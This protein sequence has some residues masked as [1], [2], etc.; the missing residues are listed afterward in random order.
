MFENFVYQFR[1]SIYNPDFYETLDKRSI[2]QSVGYFALLVA[3]VG[4]VTAA[5]LTISL[6]PRY[7]D[8][9]DRGTIL[10]Y[11]PTEGALTIREGLASSTLSEPF[12]IAMPQTWKSAEGPANLIVIDTKVETADLALPAARDAFAVLTQRALILSGGGIDMP[13]SPGQSVSLETAPEVTLDRASIE[14][15][16]EWL[17]L[18]PARVAIFFFLGVYI[19]FFL[20][21]LLYLIYFILMAP[22]AFIIARYFQHDHVN[23]HDAYIASIHSFT[24]PIVASGIFLVIG[25]AIPFWLWGTVFSAVI[26]YMNWRPMGIEEGNDD[27]EDGIDEEKI[28]PYR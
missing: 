10:T 9:V 27:S 12:P 23:Y 8:F 1:D 21:A 18:H 6:I 7:Q 13:P 19:K 26:L 25:L 4:F 3:L 2:A 5:L 22:F 20:G 16:N 17:A 14:R 11:L 24:L 28:N 15:I